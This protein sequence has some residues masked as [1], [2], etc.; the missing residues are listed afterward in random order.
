[1]YQNQYFFPAPLFYGPP[2]IFVPQSDNDV[3]INTNTTGPAG[4]PG[5]IGPPGPPG[6]PGPGTECINCSNYIL[7]DKDYSIKPDDYYIGASTQ[8]PINVILPTSPPEGKIYIVK[9]EMTPPVGNRKVTLKGNGNLID[10]QNSIVLENSYE[11]ITVLFRD[12]NWNIISQY[13]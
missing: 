10:G 8:K 4:P 13:K 5:P 12:N 2:P 6:P 1:M 3:V 11:C 7:T 9:L